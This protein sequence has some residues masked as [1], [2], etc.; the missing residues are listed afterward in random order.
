MSR[1]VITGASGLLGSNLAIELIRQGHEVRATRRANTKIEHL[2]E[3]AIE[4]CD[5]DLGDPEA[6]ARAFA[7]AD[8]VFH[9]AALVS[10][11][12]RATPALLAA[13]V[14]GTKHVLAAMRCAGAG[15]LIHCSTVGAVGLSEDGRPCTEDARWNFAELGMDDGY[16]TT[17]HMAEEVVHA[18]VA[19]GQDAVIVNPCWMFG[20]YDARPSSGRMIVDLVRGRV[21]GWTPGFNNFV[22]VR[23][24]ARG[25]ILAWQRGQRGR[26]YIL[27]GENLC[28]R[29]MF[30]RIAAIAGVRP[31]RRQVPRWLAMMIGRFGDL[32]ERV[33][34]REPL[35]NSVAAGYGYCT[36]FQFSSERARAE[37]GY[38]PGPIEPAITDALAWF[39]ER[40]Y[41]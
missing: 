31:P 26:R 8:A 16:V 12:R 21:P 3:F 39:R 20:P 23:D 27:G 34:G 7:G 22:D 38:A 10:I 4:W 28:Y 37:L 5:A 17:K 9:C 32:Q 33:T 2:Q 29:D 18:A 30:A 19:A 6:L 40:G 24:V 36:T 13:N 35:I 41:L 11:Q 14:D 15:R 1:T 25:M